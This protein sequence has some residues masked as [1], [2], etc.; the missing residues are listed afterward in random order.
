MWY[1]AYCL[2]PAFRLFPVYQ[3]PLSR[4]GCFSNGAPLV[5]IL[6]I[7][8]IPRRIILIFEFYQNFYQKLARH[9]RSKAP[10]KIKNQRSPF[11][12]LDKKSPSPR[13]KKTLESPEKRTPSTP[14]LS[15]NPQFPSVF[16]PSTRAGLLSVFRPVSD[17]TCP[18]KRFPPYGRIVYLLSVVCPRAIRPRMSPSPSPP[19]PLPQSSIS[20]PFARPIALFSSREK[21]RGNFASLSVSLCERLIYRCLI[22]SRE[23]R[24]KG[25]LLGKRDRDG[26][27]RRRKG[28][29][30]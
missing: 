24:K 23:G 18:D 20:G 11:P 19:L 21:A 12:R 27:E 15:P 4:P 14:R 22:H 7:R 3:L 30:L 16:H 8:F 17:R 28:E 9:V 6:D 10:Q 5:V 2:F 1:Y 25:S 29:N 13:G 26:V